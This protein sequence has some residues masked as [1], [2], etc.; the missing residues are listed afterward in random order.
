MLTRLIVNKVNNEE[1]SVYKM[2]NFRSFT[3]IMY[4]FSNL[5]FSKFLNNCSKVEYVVLLKMEEYIEE[6][7]VDYIN[8]TKLSEILN[9]STPAVSRVLKTLE[10]KKYIIRNI[11]IFCRRNT[12]VRLTDLGREELTKCNETLNNIFNIYFDSLSSIE[13]EAFV[14]SVEKI[15]KIFCEKIQ[16]K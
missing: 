9:V 13:Q 11:D 1:R 5:D 6:N 10:T 14:N 4:S 12:H 2:Q 3:Q 8:V 15:Y 7:K 16:Q